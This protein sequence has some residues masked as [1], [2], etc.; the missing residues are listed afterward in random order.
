M[1]TNESNTMQIEKNGIVYTVKQNEFEP[2]DIFVQRMWFV[3]SQKP[4]NAIDYNT[5]VLESNIWSNMHYLGC[6]YNSADQT[7]IRGLAD[8]M[9]QA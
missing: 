8:K 3:V 6:S 4:M 5:A 9:L 1:D 7:R 2:K